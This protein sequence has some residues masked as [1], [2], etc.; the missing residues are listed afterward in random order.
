MAFVV[1]VGEVWFQEKPEPISDITSASPTTCDIRK[2]IGCDRTCSVI[3]HC[4]CYQCVSWCPTVHLSSAPS[5]FTSFSSPRFS[6]AGSFVSI[7]LALAPRPQHLGPTSS[8]LH[9]LHSRKTEQ[10]VDR[11]FSFRLGIKLDGGNRKRN[12]FE[13]DLNIFIMHPCLRL[14][15]TGYSK[16]TSKQI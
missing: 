3:K 8:L 6:L 2:I 14:W 16:H 10:P 4:V 13:H 12:P 15:V 1:V 9:S 11:I 7:T 5:F